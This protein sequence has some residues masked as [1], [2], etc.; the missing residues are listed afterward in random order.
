MVALAFALV[1]EV[2]QQLYITREENTLQLVL[3]WH[4]ITMSIIWYNLIRYCMY[5]SINDLSNWYIL[6][7]EVS[8]HVANSRRGFRPGSVMKRK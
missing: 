6:K 5:Y 2:N 1:A 3:L 8:A 7:M 4:D